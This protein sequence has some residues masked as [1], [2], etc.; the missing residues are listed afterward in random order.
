MNDGFDQDAYNSAYR[1]LANAFYNGDISQTAEAIVNE[2]QA[3][4]RDRG[5]SYLVRL[6]QSF[7]GRSELV[8][9]IVLAGRDGSAASVGAVD[10]AVAA[11][12]TTLL[13]FEAGQAETQAPAAR[14]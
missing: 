13:R 11:V 8:R 5:M 3:R 10:S 9:A 6:S 4:Q 14:S 12:A 1:E 2:V 7:N